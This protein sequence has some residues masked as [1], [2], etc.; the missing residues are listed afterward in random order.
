MK[1]KVIQANVKLYYVAVWVNTDG[2]YCTTINEMTVDKIVGDAVYCYTHKENNY[3][4]FSTHNIIDI[5][6]IDV[7]QDQYPD[8]YYGYFTNRDEGESLI[9]HAVV[10]DLESKIKFYE[11]KVQYFTDKIMN[12]KYDKHRM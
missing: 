10:E 2:E 3:T 5:R 1:N 7:V 8:Y 12:I 6:D 4:T 9:Y 11:N